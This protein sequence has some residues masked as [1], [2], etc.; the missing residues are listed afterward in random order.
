MMGCPFS[1]QDSVIELSTPIPTIS[2]GGVITK[3]PVPPRP[4]VIPYKTDKVYVAI[5]DYDART[6]DDLTFRVGD[7]LK[8]IDDRFVFVFRRFY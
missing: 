8:I 5:Y 4:R 3:N 2:N 1:K 6:D 7:L